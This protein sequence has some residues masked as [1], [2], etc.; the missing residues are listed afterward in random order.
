ML[1]NENTRIGLA[2][3]GGGTRAAVFHLGILKWLAEKNLLGNISA[4]SSV[5]GASITIGLIYSINDYKWPTSDE[6]LKKVLPKIQDLMTSKSLQ[7]R[8]F[9]RLVYKPWYLNRR[10]NILA[11]SIKKDFGINGTIDQ[12]L[13]YPLW[14]INTTNFET[15]KNWRISSKKMGDYKFGCTLKP[16]MPISIA[17]AASAGFPIFIGSYALKTKKYQWFEYDE[18]KEPTIKITPSLKTVHLWD[19]GV[20]DNLGTEALI[21]NGVFYKDIDYLLVSDAA[22]EIK[23][24]ERSKLLQHKNLERLISIAI[25]QIRSLRAR[26]IVNY[27]IGNPHKGLYMKIGRTA[28]YILGNRKIPHP[29]K[30]KIMGSCINYE[31]AMKV[32][33]FDTDLKKLTKE[34]FGLILK[35]GYEVIN[36]T[37]ETYENI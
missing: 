21:K 35:H 26:Q 19:G 22:G 33:D 20:Y 3:S 34:K 7:F 16:N 29:D 14:Q 23:T 30:E 15:G 4:I 2:L 13:S 1:N 18:N 8:T 10:V 36:C 31:N 6:Y 27:F 28:E 17:I 37:Y 32:Q 25:D 12:L 5:S 11:E 24:K 9:L